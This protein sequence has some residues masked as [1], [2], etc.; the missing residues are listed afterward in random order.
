MPTMTRQMRAETI[1]KRFQ[2]ADAAEELMI[3]AEGRDP[4]VWTKK[5]ARC[6]GRHAG[7]FCRGCYQKIE[8]GLVMVWEEDQNCYHQAHRH[9]YWHLECHPDWINREF[10]RLRRRVSERLAAGQALWSSS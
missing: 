2:I 8:A 10:D 9:H 4:A 7:A 1:K 3:A 5:R 6:R